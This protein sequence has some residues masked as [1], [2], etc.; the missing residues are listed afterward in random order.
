MHVCALIII[1][2][3]LTLPQGRLLFFHLN[4]NIPLLRCPL[5]QSQKEHE[6][7]GSGKWNTMTTDSHMSNKAC[8]ETPRNTN[9]MTRMPAGSNAGWP[10]GS[11]IVAKLLAKLCQG[12]QASAQMSSSQEP[13]LGPEKVCCCISNTLNSH[14]WPREHFSARALQTDIRTHHQRK[15]TTKLGKKKKKTCRVGKPPTNGKRI[16]GWKGENAQ[17]IRLGENQHN[18]NETRSS[19]S[20]FSM[21]G[22]IQNKH[23]LEPKSLKKQPRL[24]GRYL[25]AQTGNCAPRYRTRLNFLKLLPG[26]SQAHLLLLK[27]ALCTAVLLL[28]Q[29]FSAASHPGSFLPGGLG[30]FLLALSSVRCPSQHCRSRP[31]GSNLLPLSRQEGETRCLY[32]TAFSSKK[33]F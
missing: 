26:D 8:L 33:P 22:H 32:F 11:I 3:V 20:C 27:G 25:E 19:S 29:S 21:W 13:M 31:L 28:L 30:P 14:Y 10:W 1:I 9:G 23:K 18:S 2:M 16:H 15:P 6:R 5:P 7:A 24:Q 4:P 17:K 12:K